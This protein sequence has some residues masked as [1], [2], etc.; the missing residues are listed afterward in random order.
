MTSPNQNPNSMTL[1]SDRWYKNVR[2]SATLW[3]PSLQVFW[4]TVAG[5][6]NLP[7]MEEVVGVLGA[8]NVLAG[9]T[10]VLAKKVYDVT[11]VKYNGEAVVSYDPRGGKSVRIRF[12]GDADQ[13]LD[14]N[15]ELTLKV[16]KMGPPPFTPAPAEDTSSIVETPTDRS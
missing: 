7:Y 3:I 2:R 11:G 13:V 5:I 6:L 4:I 16:T 8:L 12:L 15:D 10:T 1:L 9:G 14:D